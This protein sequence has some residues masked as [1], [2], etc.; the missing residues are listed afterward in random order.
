MARMDEIAKYL[1]AEQ[2]YE[3]GVEL[4]DSGTEYLRIPMPDA[5]VKYFIAAANKG[6]AGAKE[7]LAQLGVNEE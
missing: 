1:T 6:H 3:H 4:R 7:A 2:L 5:A